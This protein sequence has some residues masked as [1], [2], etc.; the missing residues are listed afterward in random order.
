MAQQW[1][2]M[3]QHF[4]KLGFAL[5]MHVSGMRRPTTQGQDSIEQ[6]I[7]D[8]IPRHGSMILSRLLR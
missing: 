5:S 2:Y 6:P 4:R 8:D 7:L 1:V 3:R